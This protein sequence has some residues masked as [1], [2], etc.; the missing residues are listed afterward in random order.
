[1]IL[2]DLQYAKNTNLILQYC[3][4]LDACHAI[5]LDMSEGLLPGLLTLILTISFS[6]SFLMRSATLRR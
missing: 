3:Q 1:M 5:I 4:Q 6:A 2:F